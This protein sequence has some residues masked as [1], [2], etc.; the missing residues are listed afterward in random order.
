MQPDEGHSKF[1][2]MAQLFQ[3]REALDLYNSG[4]RIMLKAREECQDESRRKEIST[5]LSSAYCACAELFMTDLCDE[6]K[7]EEEC[8]EGIARAEEAC[9]TNAEAKQTKARF[10][11]VKQDFEVG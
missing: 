7:A 10:L 3:G 4:I 5:E 8:K 2:A 11:L 1:L 9:P 6:E